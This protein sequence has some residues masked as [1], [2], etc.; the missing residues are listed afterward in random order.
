M[1]CAPARFHFMCTVHGA[2]AGQVQWTLFDRARGGE[3]DRRTRTLTLHMA[4]HIARGTVP[5]PGFSV[6]G[7]AWCGC[8][9]QVQWT[10]CDRRTRW[11]MYDAHSEGVCVTRTRHPHIARGTVTLPG[12][13]SCARCMVRVQC[14]SAMDLAI[15]ARG[16]ECRSTPTAVDSA[17][18]HPPIALAPC[19]LPLQL[20]CTVHGG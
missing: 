15:D 3:N 17:H 9:V 11:R 7:R 20:L 6:H 10:L 13:M 5:L 4:P 1:C 18:G 12:S 8:K 16:G 14:P 19:A 2:G